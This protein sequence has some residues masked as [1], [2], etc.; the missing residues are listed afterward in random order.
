MLV[1]NEVH[2]ILMFNLQ[3]STLYK[4]CMVLLLE[5]NL[6]QILYE[7]RKTNQMCDYS[8]SNQMLYAD[9]ITEIAPYVR[10]YFWITI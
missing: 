3:T 10:T 7:W 5:G 6:E 4:A 9:Q 1:L 2:P 8:R